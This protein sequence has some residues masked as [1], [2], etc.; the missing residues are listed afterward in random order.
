M[1][2]GREEGGYLKDNHIIGVQ[3]KFT[4][5]NLLLLMYTKAT[6]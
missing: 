2:N 5:M 6:K 4:R 1:V 3:E